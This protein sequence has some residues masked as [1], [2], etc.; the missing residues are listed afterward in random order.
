[1]LK[2]LPTISIERR[3]NVIITLSLLLILGDNSNRKGIYSISSNIHIKIF[4]KI[5]SGPPLKHSPY[6]M[7][8][9]RCGR[10]VLLQTCNNFLHV[11]MALPL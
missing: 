11:D 7:V 9:P 8:H 1:M 6:Y 4:H 10:L 3:E 5:M 2:D